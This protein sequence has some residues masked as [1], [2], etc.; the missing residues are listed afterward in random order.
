VIATDL[1]N[2]IIPTSSAIPEIA[3]RLYIGSLQATSVYPQAAMFPISR[4]E[5]IHEANVFTE[6]IQFSVYADYLSSAVDIAD[7]IKD[8]V[9]RYYGS[10]ST[11]YRIVNAFFDNTTWLYDDQVFKHVSILDMIIRY[12]KL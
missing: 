6:R 12:V 3:S 5:E 4:T 8:K 7:A 9:K 11:N 2:L 1:R 10:P